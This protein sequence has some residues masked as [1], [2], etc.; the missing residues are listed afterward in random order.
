MDLESNRF[1]Q[2]LLYSRTREP[3]GSRDTMS[4]PLGRVSGQAGPHGVSARAELTIP[5]SNK[6]VFRGHKVTKAPSS[7]TRP[8]L[9][10]VVKDAQ[11]R[12]KPSTPLHEHTVSEVNP[13]ISIKPKVRTQGSP[14]DY[15]PP[16]QTTTPTGSS[17]E[18]EIKEKGRDL[19][20]GFLEEQNQKSGKPVRHRPKGHRKRPA[21]RT[22]GP[23]LSRLPRDVGNSFKQHG[24]NLRDGLFDV[25]RNGSQRIGDGLRDVS[26][27]IGNRLGQR[28]VNDDE[29]SSS[30]HDSGYDTDDYDE[31]D[32]Y[33]DTESVGSTDSDDLSVTD[34]FSDEYSDQSG[35]PRLERPSRTFSDDEQARALEEASNTSDKPVTE[36]DLDSV[37]GD[38][39]SE[40]LEEPKGALSKL[41]GFLKKHKTAICL[42][43][44]VAALVGLVVGLGAATAGIGLAVGLV[45]AGS[46]ALGLGLGMMIAAETNSSQPAPAPNSG[47]SGTDK[48][49]SEPENTPKVSS[50]SSDSSTDTPDD[51]DGLGKTSRSSD[52]QQ[53]DADEER[54]RLEK[55]NAD[56]QAK[57]DALQQKD[58]ATPDDDDDGDAVSQ[59][60]T[61]SVSTISKSTASLPSSSSTEVKLKSVSS[62]TTSAPKA[63]P[64]VTSAHL[65]IAG[66]IPK[67][68]A[69]DETKILR[70][71]KVS[72]ARLGFWVNAVR[73][74]IDL[75][76][77]YKLTDKD[78]AEV[79][80]AIL[81]ALSDG[82]GQF[83][84]YQSEKFSQVL[85]I[86]KFSSKKVGDSLERIF[87]QEKAQKKTRK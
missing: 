26:G 60:S 78:E 46:I 75:V 16:L 74:D 36:D 69:E 81:S 79:R 39:F 28:P 34:D 25:A 35:G 49:K 10:S 40:R 62:T 42:G 55:E 37:E 57:L 8:N 33:S 6:G 23:D 65:D 63:S 38:D 7:K 61:S 32:E 27:A 11:A 29:V 76:S 87:N 68:S 45:I 52:I 5:K 14:V 9:L 73:A 3:T 71:A 19:L 1:V 24:Q 2:K 18:E 58:E 12:Q 30:G 64:Q 47:D 66:F 59:V 53:D 77:S 51:T 15:P 4:G 43:V 70:D 41:W 84:S 20:S 48:D 17:L 50:S 56:L 44:G 21:R 72:E 85:K 86:Y 83:K 13:R 80:S 82:S 22:D 54:R 31:F 67:Y